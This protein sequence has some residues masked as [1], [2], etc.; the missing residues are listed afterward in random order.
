MKLTTLLAILVLVVA[1]A[2]VKTQAAPASSSDSGSAAAYGDASTVPS[3]KP[4]SKRFLLSHSSAVYKHPDKT[5][6]V[7]AH[8]KARTHV[9]V[10]GIT[11]DWL[12]IKVAHG[13]VGF[14][15]ETA[16]E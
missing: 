3:I 4:I 13:T 14:I 10:I 1:L 2:A 15:P 7:V 5:S 8:V 16:A 11:G 9:N 6:A 12:Q